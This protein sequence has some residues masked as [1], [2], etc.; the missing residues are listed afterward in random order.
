MKITTESANRMLD[1]LLR[2]EVE[3]L[4]LYWFTQ[5]EL[6]PILLY[7]IVKGSSNQHDY[8]TSVMAY[9]S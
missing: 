8:K 9:H 5:P 1:K 7:K 2:R 6:R 4:G 3:T